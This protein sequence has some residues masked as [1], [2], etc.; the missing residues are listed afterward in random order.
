[1]YQRKINL[2]TII[3]VTILVGAT[4]L[5]FSS[6][7]QAQGPKATAS[8]PAYTRDLD[9][10]S[11]KPYH[12]EVQGST[13]ILKYSEGSYSAPIYFN[14]SPELPGNASMV[15]EHVSGVLEIPKG[16]VPE[17]MIETD[18]SGKHFLPLVK[19]AEDSKASYWVFSQPVRM[20]ASR[21]SE[22]RIHFRGPAISGGL[23]GW[24]SVNVSGY[25][26]TLPFIVLPGG[27]VLIH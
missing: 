12:G 2:L 6:S 23:G 24:F 19:H 17:V 27:P 1:M 15:I 21:G 7:L 14:K 5:A 4:L 22:V 20:Y 10:I 25:K 11:R 3:Q 9:T 13:S 16:Y 26:E 8:D 18:E